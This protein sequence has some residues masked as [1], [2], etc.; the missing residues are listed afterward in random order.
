MIR[1]VSCLLKLDPSLMNLLNFDKSVISTNWKIVPLYFFKEKGK[2][3]H[4]KKICYV[5]YKS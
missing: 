4:W 1:I 2:I 3:R 5:S